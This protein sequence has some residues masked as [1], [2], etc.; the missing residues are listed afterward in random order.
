MAARLTPDAKK[1]PEPTGPGRSLV[2]RVWPD[3]GPATPP[4]ES[5]GTGEQPAETP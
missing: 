1:R 2:Y 4:D 3:G 5:N